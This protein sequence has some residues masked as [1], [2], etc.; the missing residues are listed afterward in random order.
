[1]F[2]DL[3]SV[4]VSFF[5]FFFFDVGGLI[6]RM[7]NRSWTVSCTAVGASSVDGQ[8]FFRTHRLPVERLKRIRTGLG[9]GLFGL[10]VMDT[11]M[12]TADMGHE[13]LGRPQRGER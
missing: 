1:M 7:M 3:F 5:G 13:V 8:R 9:K 10:H 6:M 4:V 11:R 12:N 2:F